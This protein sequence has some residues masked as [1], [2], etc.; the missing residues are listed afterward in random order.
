ME[1]LVEVVTVAQSLG[2]LATQLRKLVAEIAAFYHHQTRGA[3][4]KATKQHPFPSFVVPLDT[5]LP[6]RIRSKLAGTPALRLPRLGSFPLLIFP[7]GVCR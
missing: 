1:H 7:F 2:L 5:F 6:E 3:A 4:T